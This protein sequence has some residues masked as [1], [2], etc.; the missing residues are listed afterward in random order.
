MRQKGFSDKKIRGIFYFDKIDINL[1]T[2]ER[3]IENNI[4]IL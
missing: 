2:F 4:N 3:W 1:D